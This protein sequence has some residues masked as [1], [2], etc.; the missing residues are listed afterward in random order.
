MA[1]QVS[2]EAVL[3]ALAQLNYPGYSADLVT[4]GVIEEVTP[5]PDGA[6]SI[7]VRQATERD[8]VMQRVADGIHQA[9]THGLGIQNVEL[10]V[11][12][13]EPELGEKTGRVH[14]EGTKYI[15]AVASGKGG[16]GKSTVAANL[17]C[18]FARL[19]LGV[20]LLDADIYG[21]SV[22]MMFGT[23]D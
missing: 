16:V 18:A 23:G 10:R 3:E 6:V 5:K 4:V 14:L 1:R 12:K 13:L 2:A 17:A 9:L 20:G 11:R 8:E 21:P 22:P 7:L 19:G 15:I